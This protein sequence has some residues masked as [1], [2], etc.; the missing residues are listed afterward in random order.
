MPILTEM[1]ILAAQL[2]ISVE[3]DPGYVPFVAKLQKAK[4]RKGKDYF[5]LRVII[6][7]DAAKKIDAKPNEYVFFRAKKAMWYHMMDWNQMAATW[8]MLPNEIQKEV[9]SSG[10]P[11]PSYPIITASPAGQQIGPQ[12][13]SALAAGSGNSTPLSTAPTQS[14]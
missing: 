7:K 13:F 6:P 2:I 11:N 1:N 5:V 10:L 3:P 14:K 9:I 12:Q 4:T 8:Q